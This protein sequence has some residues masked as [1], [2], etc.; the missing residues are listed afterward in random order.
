MD[1]N[2]NLALVIAISIRD[3]ERLQARSQGE[4]RCGAISYPF[5]VRREVGG[6]H[7]L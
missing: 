6:L 7:G 1:N 5:T 2:A 3:T 4:G